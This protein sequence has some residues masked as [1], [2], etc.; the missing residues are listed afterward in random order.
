MATGSDLN[1]FTVV[2][3]TS[4]GGQSGYNGNENLVWNQANCSGCLF[5]YDYNKRLQPDGR[6]HGSVVPVALAGLYTGG[7]SWSNNWNNC[8]SNDWSSNGTFVTDTSHGDR[9]IYEIY[10]NNTSSNPTLYTYSAT[11]P[12]PPYFSI[13]NNQYLLEYPTAG[14]THHY[15][16]EVYYSGNSPRPARSRGYLHPVEAASPRPAAAARTS[17]GPRSTRATA[18]GSTAWC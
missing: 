7:N 15:Q 3:G 2:Q 11:G 14:G 9:V 18:S 5:G 16:V 1:T 13:A 17:T 8:W 6:R 12:N 4:G 10:S